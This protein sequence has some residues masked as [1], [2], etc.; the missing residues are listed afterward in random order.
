MGGSRKSNAASSV[1]APGGPRSGSRTCPRVA[2]QGTRGPRRQ[3]QARHVGDGSRGRVLAGDPLRI[4]ERDGAGRDGKTTRACS[5][6]IGASDRVD[7]EDARAV[8]G[9]S[10]RALSRRA[11]GRG[12]GGQRDADREQETGASS[13][14]AVDGAQRAR[15]SRARG[16]EA[17]GVASWCPSR[18]RS[19]A[20]RRERQSRAASPRPPTPRA[21]R[22]RCPPHQ[23]LAERRQKRV[24]FSRPARIPHQADPP[25]LAR[26]RPQTAA[27]LDPVPSRAGGARTGPV[28]H[29]VGNAHGR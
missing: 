13:A 5:R 7:L 24:M 8:P 18:A 23:A 1:A 20:P 14:R 9:R 21:H 28:V 26:Q 11:G 2:V 27:D 25:H 10:R 19:L 15:A 3:L 16:R 4:D 6:C 22:T 29:S 17:S 12:R